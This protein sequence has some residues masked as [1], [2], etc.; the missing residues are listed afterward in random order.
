MVGHLVWQSS[1]F[2]HLKNGPDKK[3]TKLDSFIRKTLLFKK[4]SRLENHSKYGQIVWFS[5]G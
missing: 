4:Q 1:C 2:N 5:N 3:A